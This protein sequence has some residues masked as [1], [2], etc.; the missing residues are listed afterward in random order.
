MKEGLTPSAAA[1]PHS[2][3]PSFPPDLN[4][5]LAAGQPTCLCPDFPCGQGS[6]RCPGCSPSLNLLR[7][8]A[9]PPPAFADSERGS[10]FSV[11][12]NQASIFRDRHLRG[13]RRCARVPP[14]LLSCPLHRTAAEK[15]F[16]HER[17]HRWTQDSLEGV[18]NSCLLR[19]KMDPERAR[20]DR[21]CL[22]VADAE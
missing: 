16:V 9:I 10:S 17:I 3:L 6:G 21:L 8:P 12:M 11:E 19:Q 22:R 2:F 13:H 5:Y 7:A 14:E 1:C 18:T 4:G 15:M 20:I